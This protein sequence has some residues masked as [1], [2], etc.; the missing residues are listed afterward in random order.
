M[1][2][3]HRTYT[4]LILVFVLVALSAILSNFTWVFT[5]FTW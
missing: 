1:L 3:W 2:Q 4:A 5:N